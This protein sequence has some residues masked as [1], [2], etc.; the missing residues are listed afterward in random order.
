MLP[1]TKNTNN[2]LEEYYCSPHACYADMPSETKKTLIE[3]LLTEQ[4]FLCAYCMARVTE[5]NAHI[6]HWYPQNP[7]PGPQT[8]EE[9][10]IHRLRCIEYDNLLAV[11]P[12]GSGKPKKEQFC[13]SSKGNKKLTYN[14]ATPE[15]HRRLGIGYKKST[16]EVFSDNGQFDRQLNEILNL[17]LP[18]LRFNRKK[19][20]E[21]LN[22]ELDKAKN[23]ATRARISSILNNYRSKDAEGKLTEYAGVA[24]YFLEK[25]LA[26]M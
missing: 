15:H 14:P 24:I 7:I 19:I 17:N 26:K 10:N 4:G 9:K 8:D 11:C 6:E 12:G 16:G 2:P 18:Q 5:K 25:R 13:D 1:I 23:S 20:I 21:N 22:R 3:S